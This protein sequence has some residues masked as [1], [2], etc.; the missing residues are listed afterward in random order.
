MP[1]KKTIKLKTNDFSRVILTDDHPYEIPFIIT[2]EGF[3]KKI[4]EKKIKILDEIFSSIE[5][6][7]PMEFHVVKDS[8]STRMLSLIHPYSQIKV[9][10]F[11]REFNEIITYFCSISKS[12]LRY[13]EEISLY[14]IG[15][16]EDARE[17]QVL[18]KD[19]SVDISMDTDADQ[20]ID[21]N[22][23]VKYA[24]S[25]FSYKKYS[26]LYKFYDSYE[27]HRL[28]RKFGILCKQDISKCFESISVDNIQCLLQSET[29]VRIGTPSKSSFE[30]EFSKLMSLSNFNRSHGI[31][32]GP[33]FSRIFAEVIL[34]QIDKSVISQLKDKNLFSG[35][36]YEIRR[37][38]DDYFIFVNSN[39]TLSQIETIIKHELRKIK[40]FL[41]DQKKKVFNRPFVTGITKAKIK[42]RET[43]ENIVSS[44]TIKTEEKEEKEEKYISLDKFY[45]EYNYKK[46][47][48]DLISKI[49]IIVH[50]NN[51]SFES[52]TGYFFSIIRSIF[53][54]IREE[55]E[56]IEHISN[57]A[58]LSR[59]IFFILEVSFFIYSMDKRAR[60]TYLLSQSIIE[61]SKFLKKLDYYSEYLVT[62]KIIIETKRIASE[63][64]GEDDTV[65]IL[66][67]LLAIN[68][69][70]SSIK[71][72]DV[73]MKSIFRLSEKRKLNY[74][75]IVVILYF[76]KNNS[77]YIE[78]KEMALD[79][80]NNL[81]NGYELLSFDSERTHLLFDLMTCPYLDDLQ[82][83]KFL[84]LAFPSYSEEKLAHVYSTLSSSYWFVDWGEISIERLLQKKELR[85]AY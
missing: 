71:L 81:L 39:E 46:Y 78:I 55:M 58:E 19:E 77:D 44:I 56:E 73:D 70:H 36:H 57:S 21:D 11:Y 33:E 12:S 48:N 18:Y 79:S 13:P 72:T 31:L 25:F 51:I 17:E 7:K 53:R 3:Y 65:E 74:F 80:A 29:F 38:V 64:D 60:S 82:K 1:R 26:F 4:L 16:G 23:S 75:D 22:K 9:S 14:Y 69:I 27:M 66:N 62:S 67:L 85:L 35:K 28:E 42:I 32:V 40:L 41:N 54:K 68:E 43:L 59:F 84:A 47:S 5:I 76:S 2:N 50:E 15:D 24:S 30:F 83:N 61:L 52:I 34:Q 10:N 6:Y 20:S 8:S 63:A 45:S 37:Y 49:K